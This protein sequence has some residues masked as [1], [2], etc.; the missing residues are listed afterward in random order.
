MQPVRRKPRRIAWLA[1]VAS[2]AFAVWACSG[3]IGLD[4]VQYRAPGDA[5]FDQTAV[6]RAIEETDGPQESD[7]RTPKECDGGF[8][9]AGCRCT[10]PS[11]ERACYLGVPGDASACG[12][13]TQVCANGEWSACVDASAPAAVDECFDGIDNDC[14]GVIDDGCLCGPNFDLC[15]GADGGLFDPQKYTMFTVPVRPTNGQ[16]FDVYVVGTVATTR[17]RAD[18]LGSNVSPDGGGGPFC[19]G[20]SARGNCPSPGSGCTQQDAGWYAVR[21]RIAIAGTGF[22]VLEA[23]AASSCSG[24]SLISHTV[25]IVD[26]G[27][28]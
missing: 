13:G 9:L 1:G 2:A 12:P 25:Q 23:H 15:R 19:W 16:P 8:D 20:A 27:S 17:P 26:A 21:H 22:V 3:V 7:A 4:D 6:D 11:A 14:N 28:D 10:T 24:T 18:Y 5:S